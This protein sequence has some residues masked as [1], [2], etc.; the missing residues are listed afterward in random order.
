MR[1]RYRVK[2]NGFYK[3]IYT[4][5]KDLENGIFILKFGNFMEELNRFVFSLAVYSLKNDSKKKHI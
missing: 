5:T 3:S 4:K 1:I 2:T